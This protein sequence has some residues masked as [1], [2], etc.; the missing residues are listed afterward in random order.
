MKEPLSFE[1]HLKQPHE[2]ALEKVTEALKVEGFGV[3]T[4]IDVRATLKNKLGEDFRPYAILGAC[5][6]PLAHRALSHEAQ[7]GLMLPCN[8][9]VEADPAGGSLVRIANPDVMLNV[10]DMDQDP[11]LREVAGEA[12]AR[13]ERVAQSLEFLAED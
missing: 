5:N 13:L 8:I 9:T 7:A 4:Q 12:R 10:G 11:V 2:Q 6:P 3:L 1:V